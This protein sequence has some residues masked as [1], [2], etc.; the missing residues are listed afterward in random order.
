MVSSGCRYLSAALMLSSATAFHTLHM[1][2]VRSPAIAIVT[3]TSSLQAL[4]TLRMSAAAAT[5]NYE[6]SAP[7]TNKLGRTLTG[8]RFLFAAVLS[9]VSLYPP[10]LCSVAYGYLADNSRYKLHPPASC[11]EV[12][13]RQPGRGDTWSDVIVRLRLRA[14]Q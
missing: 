1:I 7:S 14:H 4:Q 8:F 3:P 5:P 11:L 2:R 13:H 6:L 9:V 10:L 12:L